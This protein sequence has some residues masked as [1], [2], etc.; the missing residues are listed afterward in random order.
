MSPGRRDIQIRFIRKN[1]DG[2][3]RHDR[4]SDDIL[5]ISRLG[6]NKHRSIYIERGDEYA[7]V[8][9]VMCNNHQLLCY[10]YRMFWLTTI[11]EDPFHSVKFYI[12]GFPA[13]QLSVL[14]VQMYVPNIL[15]LILSLCWNWPTIGYEPLAP[16]RNSN[17]SLVR[18]PQES[19]HNT[20]SENCPNS[21]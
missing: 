19:T 16:E 20:N 6:E 8:D 11:D 1:A 10:L 9:I 13:F 21:T 17:H 3:A 5:R 7:T 4:R 14:S 12:P 15:D 18:D 2:T